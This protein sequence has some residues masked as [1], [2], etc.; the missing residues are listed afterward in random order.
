MQIKPLISD[1]YTLLIGELY[2]WG[3]DEGDGRL[4][5]VSGVVQVKFALSVFLPR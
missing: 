5:L 1:R 2:T 3:R 4:G